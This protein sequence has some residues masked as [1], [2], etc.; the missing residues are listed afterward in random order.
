MWI[1]CTTLFMLAAYCHGVNIDCPITNVSIK[2]ICVCTPGII[3][4]QGHRLGSIPQFRQGGNFRVLKLGNNSFT[5][6]PNNAFATLNVSEIDLSNNQIS[7]IGVSAFAGVSSSLRMLN[8]AHNQ[9]TSLP[10]A[11]GELPN[12]QSL[13]VSWNP[14]PGYK[15]G[16]HHHHGTDGLTNSVMRQIGDSITTFKFGDPS[17]TSWPQSLDHLSQLKELTVAGVNIPYWPAQ[18]F[19]GFEQTLQYLAIE[20][21][22]LEA[23]PLGISMLTGLKTLHLDHLDVSHP[24]GSPSRFNDDS[25]ISA[26]FRS[27]SQTLEQLSLDYDGLTTFP[28]GIQDL[29]KLRSLSLDGNDLEF[30]SDEAIKLLKNANVSSLSLKNCNLKR[31]P[32]AISDLTNLVELDLS[33]NKIRSIESTDLQNLFSLQTLRLNINPL[34]YVSDNS[35]CGLNKLKEFFLVNTSLTEI[36]QSFKNLRQLQ[37]LDL[38]QSDIDCTCDMTWVKAWM[39]CQGE[40]TVEIEGKCETIDQGIMDYVQNRLPTCPGFH[41]DTSSFVCGNSC[42]E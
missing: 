18:G 28:E 26:P 6:I 37:M 19:H 33:E 15:P 12:I 21:A 34:K 5:S 31:V 13:D 20:Y 2:H 3:D 16:A 24:D 41:D 14:I 38:R 1:L 36:S 17:M 8:L 10:G 11:I 32:G 40:H 35:L 27:L 25:M 9:L 4:C 22:S 7:T 42:P 30:V 23:V 39:N 29:G